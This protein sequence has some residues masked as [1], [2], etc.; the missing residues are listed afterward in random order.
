MN[1]DEIE[2]GENLREFKALT[3][4]LG[5]ALRGHQLSRN[6]FIRKIHNSF[7]RRMDHLN[8]DLALENEVSDAKTKQ[9]K[10]RAPPKKSARPAARRKRPQADYGFHFIAYVPVGGNV[11]ELDGL[12]R[13]PRKLGTFPFAKLNLETRADTV[14]RSSAIRW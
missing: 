3:K 10:K 5:T 14:P 4:D 12:S 6:T 8:A 13:G 1:A 2:L 9:A 11:W 7:T